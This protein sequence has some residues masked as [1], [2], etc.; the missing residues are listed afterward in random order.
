VKQFCSWLDGVMEWRME[1]FTQLS[2]SFPFV[3]LALAFIT[4][5]SVFSI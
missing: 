4:P 1:G 2:S 5:P 3:Y